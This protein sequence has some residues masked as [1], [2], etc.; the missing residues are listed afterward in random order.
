MHARKQTGQDRIHDNMKKAIQ[1][2]Q[3]GTGN[4]KDQEVSA[5]MGLEGDKRQQHFFHVGFAIA[6]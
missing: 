6:G 3:T 1:E 4:F 2:D 5:R